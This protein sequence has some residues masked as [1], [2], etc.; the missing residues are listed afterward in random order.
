MISKR[1]ISLILYLWIIV[2]SDTAWSQ[3]VNLNQCLLT[4]MP[5]GRSSVA[6]DLVQRAC[7]FLS[8][9]FSIWDLHRPER[10]YNECLLLNLGH[11]DNDNAALLIRKTCYDQYRS[12]FHL[13]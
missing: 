4:Y 1:S 5:S 3:V 13:R 9:E 10:L 12:N 11:V 8:D 2:G 7:N 6:V